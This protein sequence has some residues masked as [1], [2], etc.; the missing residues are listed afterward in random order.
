[1]FT[2]FTEIIQK[3]EWKDN[4]HDRRT[5]VKDRIKFTDYKKNLKILKSIF[6]QINHGK[7][8]STLVIDYDSIK[9]EIKKLNFSDEVII[10][11][12]KQL[13]YEVSD[14]SYM[15]GFAKKNDKTIL[16]SSI[17]DGIKGKNTSAMKKA[18][19]KT[20]DKQI[21]KQ[22]K[23]LDEFRAD[24]E[25]N[26]IS[27]EDTHAYEIANQKKYKIVLSIQ[28]RLIASQST[29]V[30]WES[31]MQLD[32]GINKEY[33]GKGIGEGVIVAYLVK[34]NDIQYLNSPTAR[35]LVKPMRNE[36]DQTIWIVDKIYGTASEAF[37][38]K[39]LKIFEPFS[40]KEAGVYKMPKRVYSDEAEDT[41]IVFTPEQQKMIDS[42]NFED[43]DSQADSFKQY[44][45]ERVDGSL[46]KYIKEQ[47]YEL[48]DLAIT[49]Y[50]E[51][52]PVG[53][54][55]FLGYINGFKTNLLLQNRAIRRIRFNKETA[56]EFVK[57][58]GL[59]YMLEKSNLLYDLILDC[60]EIFPVYVDKLDEDTVK[61][62]MSINY[63]FYQYISK[64]KRK[65]ILDEM[66]IYPL[67]NLTRYL[68]RFEDTKKLID[69]DLL[70]RLSED[71]RERL[72][73]SNPEFYKKFKEHFAKKKV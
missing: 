32:T 21:L 3:K 42:K 26:Q 56:Q 70:N 50:K 59:E 60:P 37:R 38:E 2:Y 51:D 71:Q 63:S 47:T 45:L 49:W 12:L 8:K 18:Y 19:E 6:T 7:F 58:L 69:A 23:A 67:Y 65:A 62:L 24:L 34:N 31:C 10:G 13:D 30:G 27:L 35:V 53:L 16:V 4:Q 64:D 22:A 20:G 9:V 36:K 68:E 25:S 5:T 39:V 73:L 48:Q 15:L 66:G 17:L 11:F 52:G 14:E 28:P 55:E 1:M 29:E 72:L 43:L 40:S 46:I 57:Y 54:T 44:V 33:V 41:K 61:K